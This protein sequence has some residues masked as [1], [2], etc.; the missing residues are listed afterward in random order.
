[1]N[2]PVVSVERQVYWL[3]IRALLEDEP[4]SSADRIP[5]GTQTANYACV[6]SDLQNIWD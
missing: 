2:V 3:C 6:L 5:E 4:E 1:M